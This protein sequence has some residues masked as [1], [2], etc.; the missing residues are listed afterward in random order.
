MAG[1]MVLYAGKSQSSLILV[2][3]YGEASSDSGSGSKVHSYSGSGTG[4]ESSCGMGLNAEGI[5]GYSV[6]CSVAKKK[7]KYGVTLSCYVTIKLPVHVQ[8][9]DTTAPTLC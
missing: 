7:F 6:V 9:K 5:L 4:I 1:S 3:A 8:Q 2:P